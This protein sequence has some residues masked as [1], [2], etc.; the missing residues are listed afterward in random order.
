LQ[1]R[2]RGLLPPPS[3]GG[4]RK[5]PIGEFFYQRAGGKEAQKG[6]KNEASEG[7]RKGHV[8]CFS[9]ERKIEKKFE[10]VFGEEGGEVL[11]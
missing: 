6:E 10:L 8:L 5:G 9:T 11:H 3:L 7:K 2:G 1:E 4:G